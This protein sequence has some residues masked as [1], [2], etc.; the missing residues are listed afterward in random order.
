L[1]LSSVCVVDGQGKIVKEAKITSEPEA[2]GLAQLRGSLG[3]RSKDG[4]FRGHRPSRFINSCARRTCS[5]SGSS[6]PH[7]LQVQSRR[8][9]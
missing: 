3:P 9:N 1:E 4:D 7:S 6:A 8:Q 2:R 5:G